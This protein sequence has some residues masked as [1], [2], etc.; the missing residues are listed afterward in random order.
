MYRRVFWRQPSLALV[1]SLVSSVA[2]KTDAAD[3]LNSA[4]ISKFPSLILPTGSFIAL[5]CGRDAVR[6]R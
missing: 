3:G 2:D 5:E 4:S 1:S 6:L